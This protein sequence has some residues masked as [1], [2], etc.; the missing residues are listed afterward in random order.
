MYHGKECAKKLGKY[1]KFTCISL[2]RHDENSASP[3]GGSGASLPSKGLVVKKDSKHSS[4]G[5][6]SRTKVNPPS[7]SKGKAKIET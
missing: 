7:H 1:P 5:P 4:K 6:S 2:S 3:H